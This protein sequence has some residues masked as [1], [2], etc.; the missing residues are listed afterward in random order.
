M[1]VGLAQGKSARYISRIRLLCQLLNR[2][3]E[4][5]VRHHDSQPYSRT[6]STPHAY[7]F[8]LCRSGT[9]EELRVMSRRAPKAWDANAIFEANQFISSRRV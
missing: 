4:A 6:K 8:P 1:D 9:P 3:T 2:L 7:I 5:F